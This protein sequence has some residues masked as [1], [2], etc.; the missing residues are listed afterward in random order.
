[1]NEPYACVHAH[2]CAYPKPWLTK[3]Q[4]LSSSINNEDYRWLGLKVH[5]RVN[6]IA[7]NTGEMR[8]KMIGK[9]LKNWNKLHV[10]Y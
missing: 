7:I 10:I 6:L 8:G 1:M 5:N 4:V 9:V 2:A 3:N